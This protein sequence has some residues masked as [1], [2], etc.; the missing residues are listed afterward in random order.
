MCMWR[1]LSN[2]D[3]S[4]LK[5]TQPL[6]YETEY[7]DW[8]YSYAGTCFPVRWKNDLYI[9][10]ALHCYE[11]YAIN[12]ECTCYPIPINEREFFGFCRTLKA[13]DKIVENRKHSDQILLK[14]A[15][16]IHSEEQLNSVEALDLSDAQSIIFLLDQG[17]KD[18][19]LQGYPFGNPSHRIDETTIMKQ[20]YVTNGL[21][22]IKK[23]SF[24]HCYFLKVKTPTPNGVSPNGMSGSPVYALDQYDRIRLAGTIIEYNCYTNEFLVIGSFILRE[25]FKKDAEG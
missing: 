6:L 12:P 2:Q 3:P 1:I 15:S 11:N 18:V 4:I 25:T 23:S 14:V 17:I 19:W 16:D 24:D 10:S 8:P 21:E 9:V 22:Y 20:A 13:R 5:S 7:E